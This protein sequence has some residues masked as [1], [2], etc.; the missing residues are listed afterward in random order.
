[1]RTG[2]VSI[3]KTKFTSQIG[4]YTIYNKLVIV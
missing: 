3:L 4:R 2:K 1:M